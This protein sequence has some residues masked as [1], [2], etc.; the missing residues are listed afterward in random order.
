MKVL[1]WYILLITFVICPST[2]GGKGGGGGSSSRSGGSK[3]NSQTSNN[4]HSKGNKN[5]NNPTEKAH[6]MTTGRSVHVTKAPQND[7]SDNN[8][9]AKKSGGIKPGMAIGGMLAAGAIGATLGR[10][11]H[12]NKNGE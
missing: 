9:D 2:Y 10:S 4:N 11:H 12:R 8:K 3:G 5:N 6:K 7:V 1:I